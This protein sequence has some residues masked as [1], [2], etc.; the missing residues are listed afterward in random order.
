VAGAKPAATD[1]N[2]QPPI[3]PSL[4]SGFTDPSFFPFF[5]VFA[6]A[7]VV[8]LLRIFGFPSDYTATIAIDA[9]NCQPD[10]LSSY[11]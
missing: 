8:N 11:I 3:G 7:M 9:P 5:T 2:N 6:F 4:P 10:P 1:R